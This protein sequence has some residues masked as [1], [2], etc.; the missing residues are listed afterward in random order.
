MTGDDVKLRRGSWRERQEK[1]EA[2]DTRLQNKSC[3]G[4]GRSPEKLKL[5]YRGHVTVKVRKQSSRLIIHQSMASLNRII[6]H[7]DLK[8]KFDS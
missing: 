8:L 3:F 5:G 2:P 7:Q 6:A 1:P 4:G